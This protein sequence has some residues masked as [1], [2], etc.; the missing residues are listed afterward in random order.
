MQNQDAAIKK[1][2][3]QIGYLFQQAPSH[4]LHSNID[5]NWREEC[6]AI[7]LRS[8]KEL[9]ETSKQPQEEDAIGRKEEQNEV[10]V[11]TSN[12]HPKGE[13]MRPYIPK[14]PYPQQLRKK[15]DD[16]QF[17]RF[18]EIFK[19]LQ[20]NI[21]FAEVIEQMPLYDKF[22]KELMTKKRSWKNN[23]TVILTEEC[24][25][26]IQHKLSQKLKDPGSLQILCIIGEITVEKALCDLGASINLM[27]VAMMRKMKIEEAKPTKMALQLADRSFKFPHGIVEDLLVK[28]GDFI[29]PT[30]FVVLD[31]KEGVKASIILGRPF[32]ATAGA[33][34]DVQKGEFTL[35]LHN[36]TMMINVFKAMNYPQEPLGECM[37][38]D[39]LED[40]VQETF[41]EEELEELTEEE[42]SASSEE[43]AT[44]EVQVQGTIEEK[45][46]KK[47]APKLELKA[48]LPTLKYAYLG[49][50]KSYPVIINSSL[51]QE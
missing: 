29:F 23:D 4:D 7:T 36:E 1:L 48:L 5:P 44:A 46:E 45:N 15:G 42:E 11:P 27:S 43:A 35:R 33:V 9:K 8:G 47:E 20:I 2:E 10:H 14:A 50:N 41:E 31:M 34:I 12:A 30:D 19:K 18:L 38:L 51:S 21:P 37:R 25:A 26:I 32:L 3:T 40:V 39:S 24:S 17:S 6:H 13:E 28:V 22:L 49:E 16:S